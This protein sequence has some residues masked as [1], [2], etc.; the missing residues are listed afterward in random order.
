MRA[1]KVSAL[2]P[3][4]RNQLISR[5][6]AAGL[7]DYA[8]LERWLA[9]LGYSIGKSSLHRTLRQFERELS[10]VGRAD[11]L[12]ARARPAKVPLGVALLAVALGDLSLG[13][14]NVKRRSRQR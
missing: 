7:A 4:V 1:S 11:F 9:K 10:L 6:A 14:A 3:R 12:R 13:T 2:P 8:G 5:A